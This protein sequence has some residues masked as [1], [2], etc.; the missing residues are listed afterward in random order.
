MS[1][2]L[3]KVSLFN[4]DVRRLLQLECRDGRIIRPKTTKRH[5][6]A[7]WSVLVLLAHGVSASIFMQSIVLRLLA[8][9]H[10]SIRQSVQNGQFHGFRR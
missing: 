6:I 1:K 8:G 10:R 5:L 3:S 2:A 7:L 4:D 9:R